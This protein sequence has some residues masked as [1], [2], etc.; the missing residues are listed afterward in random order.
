[1]VEVEKEELRA[2]GSSLQVVSSQDYILHL[3]KHHVD[4]LH[5]NARQVTASKPAA[6]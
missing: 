2:C 6:V 3:A 4:A 5:T 1:M